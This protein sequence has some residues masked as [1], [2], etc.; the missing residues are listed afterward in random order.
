MFTVLGKSTTGKII[1]EDLPSIACEVCER[2]VTELFKSVQ[3]ARESRPKH[4]LDELDVVELIEAVTNP[5]NSTGEWMRKIDIVESQEKGKTFLSLEEPGGTVKCTNECLTI[6][7]SS[8][9]LFQD[10]I[11]ADDLSALLWRNKVYL[12]GVKVSQTYA[13]FFFVTCE[14][15]ELQL[16]TVLFGFHANFRT[17]F[18][19]SGQADAN[20]GGKHW[21][22][23]TNEWTRRSN[24][25]QRR[26]CRWRK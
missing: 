11:D 1:K 26:I 9:K 18:A 10:E 3:T 17:K 20:P 6:A 21:H 4:K 13:P 22:P 19:C 14:S 24:R 2:A 12:A 15:T 23:T 5:T 16:F 8:R 25:N 7:E